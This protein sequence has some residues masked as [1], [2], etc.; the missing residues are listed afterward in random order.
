MYWYDVT[1]TS[2]TTGMVCPP[3]Y[4]PTMSSFPQF[5]QQARASSDRSFLEELS[6]YSDLP[7]NVLDHAR[8]LPSGSSNSSQSL[9]GSLSSQ[10]FDTNASYRV[11]V[12]PTDVQGHRNSTRI[13]ETVRIYSH[14]TSPH[15][16]FHHSTT[17]F[18]PGP[19][20]Q[21]SASICN[22]FVADCG[23]ARSQQ[24]AP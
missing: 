1:R 5:Y 20:P 4:P 24:P 19:T 9:Q 13:P 8:P 11:P 17:V 23:R 6:D 3:L 12:Y 18:P 21:C 10:A 16:C 14:R 22:E 15:A 7:A 2:R